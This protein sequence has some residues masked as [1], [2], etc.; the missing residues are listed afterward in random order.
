MFG[1]CSNSL[2]QTPLFCSKYFDKFEMIFQ[3]RTHKNYYYEKVGSTYFGC[4]IE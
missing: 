3:Y 1:V 4:A 2:G